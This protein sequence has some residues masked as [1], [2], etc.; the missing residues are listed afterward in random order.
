MNKS[1]DFQIETE[2]YVPTDAD[3]HDYAAWSESLD[4]DRPSEVDI[5]WA[6]GYD[7]GQ[8]GGTC[9]PPSYYRTD[10]PEWSAWMA[11]YVDGAA[12]REQAALDRQA[13]IAEECQR[14]GR[15]PRPVWG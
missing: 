7:I 11:G 10:G 6:D 9:T 5:A 3:W 14:Y 12:S 8:L 15:G 4:R 1:S 13:R 2:A